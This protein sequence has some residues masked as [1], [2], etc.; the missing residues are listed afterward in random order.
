[1]TSDK[2]A[3]EI[4]AH[5]RGTAGAWLAVVLMTIGVGVITVGICATSWPIAIVGLVVGFIGVVAGKLSNI[6][7]QVH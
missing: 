1:M 2:L 3:H 7:S 4:E 6:M 5:P